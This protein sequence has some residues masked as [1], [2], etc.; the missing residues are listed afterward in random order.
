MATHSSTLAWRIPWR[1]K[2]G[3]LQS[4]GSQFTFTFHPQVITLTFMVFQ[5]PSASV[6]N[7]ILNKSIA[8]GGITTAMKLNMPR[9]CIKKQRHHFADKGPYSQS[10][11]FSSSHV[12]MWELNY[13]VGWVLKNWCFPIVVLEKILESPLD[14]K[15]IK[16]VNPKRNHLWKFT[17]K[18]GAEAEA[19]ILCPP[20]K[21]SW[22]WKI[23]WCWEKLRARG[24]RGNRGWDG[25]MASLT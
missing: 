24:E 6:V 16:A 4:M 13:K 25:W 10:Y 18:T 1:E 9:Q 22:L 5:Y 14:S 8:V 11:G 15:E 19:P 7:N 20:E 3:R 17:G 23:P 12:W 21:N 2:P